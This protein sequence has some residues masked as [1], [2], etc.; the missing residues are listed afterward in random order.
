MN[1]TSA[2]T[3]K[4]KTLQLPFGEYA[5]IGSS[6][7]EVHGIRNAKDIDIVATP[8]LFK[9]FQVK[10]WPRK[11]FFVRA[12]WCKALSKDGLEVFSNCNHKH[13][14]KKVEDIIKDAEVIDGIPFMNLNDFKQFKASIAREKDIRDVQLIEEYLQKQVKGVFHE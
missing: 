5:V 8:K 11:W 9:E 14:S 13:F 3:D 4:I 1:N 7:L 6:V 10:G 12:F 2:T